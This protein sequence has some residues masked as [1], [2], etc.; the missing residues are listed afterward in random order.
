MKDDYTQEVEKQNEKLRE[1][2]EETTKKLVVAEEVISKFDFHPTF[3]LNHN[4]KSPIPNYIHYPHIHQNLG[5]TL[6]VLSDLVGDDIL[7]DVE[8]NDKKVRNRKCC[9]LVSKIDLQCWY[10]GSL[11]RTYQIHLYH[12][13]KNIYNIATNV[14]MP[15][16]IVPQ[17]DEYEDRLY[18]SKLPKNDD[19]R[20]AILEDLQDCKVM[21]KYITDK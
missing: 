7:T 18:K 5:A 14:D 4:R 20:K 2:L 8:R 17:W 21:H 11:E 9:K 3:V 6:E 1:L 16:G 12:I 19:V 13:G 10:L 15:A